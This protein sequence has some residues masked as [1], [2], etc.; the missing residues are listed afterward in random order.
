[1]KILKNTLAGVSAAILIASP[2]MAQAQT[3]RTAAPAEDGEQLFG[4]SILLSLLA[5]AAVVAGI[6]VIADDD[7]EPVSP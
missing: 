7:D 4:G 1:M 5:V 3:D 2:V 6:V